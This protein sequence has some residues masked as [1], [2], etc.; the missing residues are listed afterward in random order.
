[1]TEDSK[2]LY[3]SVLDQLL[4]Q[5][6]RFGPETLEERRRPWLPY[7]PKSAVVEPGLQSKA[8]NDD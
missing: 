6:H 4:A 2:N 7:L 1:M 8:E 5:D 3:Q